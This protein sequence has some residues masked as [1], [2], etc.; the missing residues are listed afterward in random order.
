MS[1]RVLVCLSLLLLFAILAVGEEAAD[2]MV[3][4]GK[5]TKDC[6]GGPGIRVSGSEIVLDRAAK[7]I[8]VEGSARYYCIEASGK[9]VL[10]GGDEDDVVG[11]LIPA[12]RYKVVP[13]L[14]GKQKKA[15]ISI[16]FEY[17]EE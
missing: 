13:A 15:A 3:L 5:K 6:C 17:E 4:W 2:G 1:W 14:R 9:A 16:S 10:C 7:I 8:S 11:K 12:G